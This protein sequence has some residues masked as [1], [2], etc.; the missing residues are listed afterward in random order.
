MKANILIHQLIFNNV[1]CIFVIIKA[2]SL[3][4]FVTEKEKYNATSD[5]FKPHVYSPFSRALFPLSKRFFLSCYLRCMQVE[6]IFFLCNYPFFLLYSYPVRPLI[7]HLIF[8][9]LPC[10]TSGGY[11]IHSWLCSSILKLFKTL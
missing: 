6:M 1:V 4:K 9:T 8:Q 2:Q 3:Y 10:V 5:S 7:R 11:I